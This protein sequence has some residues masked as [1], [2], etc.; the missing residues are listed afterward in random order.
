MR[1]KSFKKTVFNEK[2][3]LIKHLRVCFFLPQNYWHINILLDHNIQP[4]FQQDHLSSYIFL[5][6][7]VYLQTSGTYNYVNILPDNAVDKREAYLQSSVCKNI[8]NNRGMYI[9]Q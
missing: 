1:L 2:K 5:F 7:I 9:S 8:I 4:F 3:N 6:C